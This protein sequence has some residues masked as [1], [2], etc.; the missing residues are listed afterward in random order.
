MMEGLV[1]SL[2]RLSGDAAR[3]AKLLGEYEK[4]L[5]QPVTNVHLR[6]RSLAVIGRLAAALPESDL[7]RQVDE[8]A[9]AEREAIG[10]AR[11]EFRF[12]FARQLVAGLEGSGMAV[13]GQ[14]PVLR[15]GLFTLKADFGVGA[16]TVFWGPEVEKLKSGLRLE[17][18]ELARTLRAYD[19]RLRQKATEPGKLVELMHAAYRRHL[20]LAGLSPGTRVVLL[21]LL[22]EMVMLLQPA[23]FKQNPAQEK[24]VEYPRVRF[25]YDLYRLRQAATYESGGER[26]KLHVANF[27]ATTEKTRALWVP[28]NDDGDGT[29]YS[30]ASFGAA[31]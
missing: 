27:D 5:S 10:A 30:Y 22:S 3:L 6:E 11:D 19:D 15:V 8:F 12:E 17:P 9:A 24:F 18:G 14:L 20:V 28:D 31:G 21:D 16:A 26:L 2:K 7:R 13:R 25:S 1:G 23:G 4:L 29:H